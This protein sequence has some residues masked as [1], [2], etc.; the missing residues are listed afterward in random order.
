MSVFAAG[1]VR[2]PCL[3]IAARFWF[4]TRFAPAGFA[5]GDSASGAGNSAANSAL[6]PT[7]NSA[8][9]LPKYA[10][11]APAMPYTPCPQYTLFRYASKSSSFVSRVSTFRESKIS[12][13][14]LEIVRSWH[15]TRFFTSCCVIVL[16]P[17]IFPIDPIAR[18]SPRTSTPLC[19]KNRWSSDATTACHTAGDT[20]FS[21]TASED[22]V[23]TTR[24]RTSYMIVGSPAW[25]S[26]PDFSPSASELH[27]FP[28]PLAF[29]AL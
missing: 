23:A 3:A 19:L 18:V 9:D 14:F 7:S 10:A 12:D 5:Y 15:S 16:P 29:M 6:S 4:L 28:A 1:S 21:L 22:N 26:F 27:R 8:G 11:A 13:I 2:Y 17:P 20:S 24:P 25:P